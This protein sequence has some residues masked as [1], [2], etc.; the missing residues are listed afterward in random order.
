[1]KQSKRFVKVEED[2][3]G[4]VIF[5]FKSNQNT[6]EQ[7]FHIAISFDEMA[8]MIDDVESFEEVVSFAEKHRR[9]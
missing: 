2:N 4:V 8:K 9:V 1:M 3:D 6:K 7:R 5:S